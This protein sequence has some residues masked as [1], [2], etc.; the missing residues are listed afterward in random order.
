MSSAGLSPT[1]KKP[2]PSPT[3]LK[4]KLNLVYQEYWA[5]STDQKIMFKSNNFKI[6]IQY[7]N[8]SCV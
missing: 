8:G 7:S 4:L 6:K 1:F 2:C 3:I 5:W